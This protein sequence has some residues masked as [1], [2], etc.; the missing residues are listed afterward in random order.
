M[1]KKGT[2]EMADESGRDYEINVV[3]VGKG[4][5]HLFAA[6]TLCLKIDVLQ[7]AKN[8]RILIWKHI[9]F[10]RKKSYTGMGSIST[11]FLI[12][13]PHILRLLCTVLRL[14]TFLHRSCKP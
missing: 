14:A 1:N 11:E 8:G 7:A 10:Q 3:R 4:I 6:A 13:L 12:C 9:F 5:F 2:K